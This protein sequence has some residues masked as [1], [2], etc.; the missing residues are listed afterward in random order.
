[1]SGKSKVYRY[2]LKYITCAI[3]FY[4]NSNICNTMVTVVKYDR[5]DCVCRSNAIL[6]ISDIFLMVCWFK[7]KKTQ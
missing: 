3:I 7:K 4:D 5:F 1:M 6:S 2:I